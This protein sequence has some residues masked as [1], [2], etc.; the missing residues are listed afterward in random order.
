MKDPDKAIVCGTC[1]VP[2]V[3]PS[4]PKPHQQRICP[5]CGPRDS[6]EEELKVVMDHVKYNLECARISGFVKVF[7]KPPASG[8]GATGNDG[9]EPFFKW[10]IRD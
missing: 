3:T 7:G 4:D 9:Q 1:N 2:I 8:L 10:R 6:Y 5:R